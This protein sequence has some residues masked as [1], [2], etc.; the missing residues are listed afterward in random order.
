M[1][2]QTQKSN[3]IKPLAKTTDATNKDF[4]IKRSDRVFIAGKTGSGKTVLAQHLLLPAKRLIVIDGKDGIDN[5]A[6]R[7]ED[8]NKSHLRQLVNNPDEGLRVRLVNNQKDIIELLNVVYEVGN[9]MVYIDEITMT[10]PPQSKPPQIYLDIWARGRQREIGAW[11]N[12]QRPTQI[13]LWFLSESTHFFMFR[14]SLEDDRK[15]VY[16]MIGDKRVITEKLDEHG[17]WYYN[18]RTNE[19]RK[20]KKINV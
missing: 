6:W 13:P 12:T 11:G 2:L 9:C 4:K 17:F 14:L 5:T 15:R 8:Y 1:S 19:L 7:L 16:Q 3:A 20:Y 18:D 10:I